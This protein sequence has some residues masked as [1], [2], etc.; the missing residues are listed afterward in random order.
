MTLKIP[1][2]NKEKSDFISLADI[3]V[4]FFSLLNSSKKETTEPI[5]TNN[6]KKMDSILNISL[7]YKFAKNK[8]NPKAR[9]T[10]PIFFIHLLHYICIRQF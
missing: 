7:L 9:N 2:R 4:V 6:A 5:N 8:I 3:L 10:I 1:I